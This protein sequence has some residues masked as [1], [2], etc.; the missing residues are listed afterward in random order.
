MDFNKTHQQIENLFSN[1]KDLGFKSPAGLNSW[2]ICRV[3]LT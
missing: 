1:G 3:S 2:G